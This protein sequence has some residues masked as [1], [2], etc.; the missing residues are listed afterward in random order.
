M[1]PASLLLIA[2][3]FAWVLVD[4]LNTAGGRKLAETVARTDALHPLPDLEAAHALRRTLLSRF[5]LERLPELSGQAVVPQHMWDLYHF[6]TGNYAAVKDSSFIA[7][8]HRTSGTNTFRCFHHL[9]QEEG[10][11]LEGANLHQMVFNLTAIPVGEQII[12]AELRLYSEYDGWADARH[13]RVGGYHLWQVLPQQAAHR[14][15]E[16]RQ[17][18]A[19]QS[20]WEV[21]DVGQVVEESRR[22]GEGLVGFLVK[23]GEAGGDTGPL[24]VSRLLRGMEGS[25][26]LRRPLLVTY[27]LD[28]K[29]FPLHSRPEQSRRKRNSGRGWGRSQCR[30]KPLYVDFRRVGWTEWI[31]APRGYNAFYCQGDCRFPLADHMNSSSHAI[32]QTL[33][34]AVN[35]KVPRACCVPT[36]LSPVAI[37]YLDEEERVVLRSYQEMVVEG[38]G[39]R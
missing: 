29:G 4:G 8:E 5:G 34:H 7:L 2:V 12:S 28:G 19:N 1:L 32:V 17:S 39:C 11:R 3:L 16:R 33:V 18:P 24:R 31:I 13:Q 21:F 23:V 35:G 20:Q 15:L 25:W 27:G 30:R 36:E 14:L 38:C 37:L 6:H 22:M 10:P 26:P 9:D